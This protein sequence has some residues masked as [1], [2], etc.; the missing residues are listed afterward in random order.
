MFNQSG[1]DAKTEGWE[2]KQK[3]PPTSL[4]SP[5]V[6]EVISDCQLRQEMKY[7]KYP[8]GRGKLQPIRCLGYVQ[9]SKISSEGIVVDA[10]SVFAAFKVFDNEALI[11]EVSLSALSSKVCMD[12]CTSEIS[13][14]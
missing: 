5:I 11:K 6:R 12:S 4:E 10:N 7:P 2:N 8:A 14:N 1:E 9:I 13:Q 3:E